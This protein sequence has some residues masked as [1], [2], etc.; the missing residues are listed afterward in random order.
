MR[1]PV[2][3]WVGH[4]NVAIHTINWHFTTEDARTELRRLSPVWDAGRRT[5]TWLPCP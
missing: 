3:T 1:E 4:R 2:T 5:R